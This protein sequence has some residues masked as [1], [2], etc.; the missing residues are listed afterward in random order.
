MDAQRKV[1]SS[2]TKI[3]QDDK[4]TSEAA[5][6]ERITAKVKETVENDEANSVS[7]EQSTGGGSMNDAVFKQKLGDGS[8]DITA[9]VLKRAAALGLA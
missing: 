6:E 1:L 3:Q 5:L 9:E 2:V 8:L 4:K 7:T